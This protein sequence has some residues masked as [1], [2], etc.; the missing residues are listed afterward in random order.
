MTGDGRNGE[1]VRV[2]VGVL[3]GYVSRMQ[4][5]SRAAFS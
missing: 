5:G 1:G 4:A 3:I 2:R